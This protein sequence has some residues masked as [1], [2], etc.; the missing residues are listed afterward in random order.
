[1]RFVYFEL[2][3]DSG[4]KGAYSFLYTNAPRKNSKKTG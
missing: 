4:K 2:L 3:R 1:M